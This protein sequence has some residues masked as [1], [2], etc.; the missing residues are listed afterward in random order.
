[1]SRDRNAGALAKLRIRTC[2]LVRHQKWFDLN[3]PTTFNELV[4]R[5]KLQN[6]DMRMVTLADKVA[7]KAVVADALG[8]DWIIPTFW[9]GTALPE[10][11]DWPRPFVI[12]SRHG[13]NQN[14]FVRDDNF[15]W[16]ALQVQ[17][18]K[19]MRRHYGQAGRMALCPYSARDVG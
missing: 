17:A 12:K 15:I 5:R 11:P 1:V 9:H 3:T 19:W 16:P 4:Q 13:T 2:Y 18:A 8:A 14:I 6:R 7:V 10:R